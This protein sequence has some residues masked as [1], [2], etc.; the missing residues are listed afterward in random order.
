MKK[1]L[2]LNQLYFSQDNFYL[3]FYTYL[4]ILF[5]FKV[6]G[7]LFYAL[8][9]NFEFWCIIVL[10]WVAK[11][12]AKKWFNIEIKLSKYRSEKVNV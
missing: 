4:L 3:E 9:D 12:I 2:R 5:L 1:I 10:R 6:W 11:E 8:K 7:F